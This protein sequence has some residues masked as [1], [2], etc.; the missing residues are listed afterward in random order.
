MVNIPY[1]EQMLNSRDVMRRFLFIETAKNPKYCC[2]Y[3][4]MP[5]YFDCF[6]ILCIYI[7]NLTVTKIFISWI[8]FLKDELSFLLP[9]SSLSEMAGVKVPKA[10]RH[11]PDL[12]SIIDCTELYIEK[13]FKIAAQ[14]STYSSCKARNTFKVLVGISPIPHFNFAS[15]LLTGSVSDKEIVAKSGFLK[16]LNPGDAVMG[17]KGFN[18][19][20]LMALHEERLIAPPLM[21]K[22]TI[23]SKASTDTRRIAKL[24]VHVERHIRKLKCY[25]I[26]RGVIPLSLKPYVNHIVKVCA[27][28]VNLQPSAISVESVESG[29]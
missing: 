4:G 25:G 21:R 6:L 19:Q 20:D 14:R 18:I 23:S 16:H 11:Y 26:L 8:M 9:F 17:D 24:H 3:T 29:D 15:Q 2:H 7:K 28:L 27:A 22:E 5:L 12:R 10:F 1:T 13:P